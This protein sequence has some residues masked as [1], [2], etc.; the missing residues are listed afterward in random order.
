M[1][2]FILV[3]DTLF[4]LGTSIGLDG[5]QREAAIATAPG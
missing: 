1:L 5:I 4:D 2:T 3:Q